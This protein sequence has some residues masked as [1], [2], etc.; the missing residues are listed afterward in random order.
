VP[1]KLRASGRHQGASRHIRQPRLPHYTALLDYRPLPPAAQLF[2]VSVGWA[3]K[4][5]EQYR[6]SGQTDRVEQ[7][8]SRRAA[9]TK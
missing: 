3:E 4:V 1:R 8:T 5:S 6:R 7:R 9:W 2:G